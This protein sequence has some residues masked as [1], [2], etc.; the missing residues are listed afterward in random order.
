LTWQKIKK[1]DYSFPEEFD[2]EAKD[3]I[4]KLLVCPPERL[5]IAP[6]YAIA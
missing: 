4:Q 6:I 2:D 1:L 3:L 5:H